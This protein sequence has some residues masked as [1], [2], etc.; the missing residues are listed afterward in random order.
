MTQKDV[1]N[2]M[3]CDI[4][5]CYL[6]NKDFVGL[7][8]Y[9]E[10]PAHSPLH[11]FC[12]NLDELNFER[13]DD[14]TVIKFV[15]YLETTQPINAIGQTGETPLC[16]A[17]IAFN[18]AYGEC[19][20]E[21]IFD[22][23]RS[24]LDLKASVHIGSAYQSPLLR[25]L[26]CD[27]KRGDAMHNRLAWLLIDRGADVTSF[28]EGEW[29]SCHSNAQDLTQRMM[30]GRQAAR[31]VTLLIIGIRRYKRS[32]LMCINN[33]DIARVIAHHVWETRVQY[34]VWE[35]SKNRRIEESKN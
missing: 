5:R 22:V 30:N 19:P 2:V 34:E 20:R 15:T 28:I 8:Q 29:G 32:K 1:M 10:F 9:L 12:I 25:L 4:V 7:R 21:C 23:V 26:T 3:W 24:L 11:N 6:E 18:C 27:G 35:E 16:L 33:L 13:V 17:I 31:H 14:Q